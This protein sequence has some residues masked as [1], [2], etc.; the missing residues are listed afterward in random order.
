VSR[1]P[2]KPSNRLTRED[3]VTAAWKILGESGPGVPSIQA[4]SERLGVSRGSFYWH[5]DDRRDFRHAMLEH[6]QQVETD[7]VMRGMR[8]VTGPPAARVQAL[9]KFLGQNLEPGLEALMHDWARAD[10]EIADFLREEQE[11]R[12]RFV[13]AMLRDAGCSPHDA[14]FRATAF[15]I[16]M[17]GWHLTRPE[18]NA[19]E[20]VKYARKLG[21]LFGG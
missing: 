12:I 1:R 2:A 11:R 21:E 16:L 18:R 5:F 20:L 7:K 9:A 15:A 10:P 14:R 8:D 3:W 19:V 13:T 4:M 17:A 6:W